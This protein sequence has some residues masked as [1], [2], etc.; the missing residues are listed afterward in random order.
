MPQLSVLLAV[1]ER[2]GITQRLK[3]SELFPDESI[4]LLLTFGPIRIDPWF[5]SSAN[6]IES[7]PSFNGPGGRQ[8]MLMA[9]K[10]GSSCIKCLKLLVLSAVV[11]IYFVFAFVPRTINAGLAPNANGI[12]IHPTCNGFRCRERDNQSSG[13]SNFHSEKGL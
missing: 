8:D 7:S 12:E 5:V 11:S 13:P 3:F 6:D 1:Q 4:D 9:A 10:K 2:F